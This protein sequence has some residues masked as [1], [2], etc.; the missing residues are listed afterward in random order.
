MPNFLITT[1]TEVEMMSKDSKEKPAAVLTC[2]LDSVN[3]ILMAISSRMKMSG[4]DNEKLSIK[5]F[6]KV[7]KNEIKRTTGKV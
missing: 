1:V 2:T 5:C 7:F 6:S 4:K 3:P